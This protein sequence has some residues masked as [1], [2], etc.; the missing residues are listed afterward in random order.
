MYI[1]TYVSLSMYVYVFSP[2]G[3]LRANTNGFGLDPLGTSVA[4]PRS[5]TVSEYAISFH[6][7]HL[8][9]SQVC[10]IRQLA[11]FNQQHHQII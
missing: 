11:F 5:L 8:V 9:N 1:C 6:S 3:L 10:I 7:N 2:R 4:A